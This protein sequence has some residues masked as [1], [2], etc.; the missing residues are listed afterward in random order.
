MDGLNCREITLKEALSN[1]DKRIDSQFWTTHIPKNPRYTYL[2]IGNV[3]LSSQYGM[4]INMNTEKKGYPIF[5]MNELH[6]MLTDLEVE[7]YANVSSMEYQAFSLQN[8]D[9]LFNRTNSYE[10]V[11]R[12]GIYYKNDDTPFTYASYLVKFVPDSSIILPEYLTTFLNTGIGVKAIKARARQSVN[13]TNVNPEEVKEIEIPLLSMRF[14][15]AIE[16]LFLIANEKRVCARNL[17]EQ[18]VYALHDYLDVK[19]EPNCNPYSEKLLSASF[20]VSGRFDAE[21]YQPKYERYE[22]TIKESKYGFTFI[23]YEFELISDKCDRKLPQYKYVEIGDINIGTG[24]ATPNVVMTEDLPDNAKIMT[25]VDDILVS[26]VRPNRGA[27]SILT[28]NDL[29]VSGAFT[30]LRETGDYPKEVLQLLLRSE[31]YRDWMLKYNVGTS[32][33]V[34]KDNDVLNLPIPILGK[35]EKETIVKN[36]RK[37]SDLRDVSKHLLDLA[38]KTVEM[39]I[40]QNED[41][42]LA[43]LKANVPNLEV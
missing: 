37:S 14:Q 33:P 2:K 15:K 9:V 10:W 28:Q 35:S 30:V 18:A 13:Q 34:I 42:A 21:Y 12:T 20:G 31:M 8:R 19:L 7:K 24:V 38:V 39:A 3:I 1:K 40:E 41:A 26:T 43:W 6:H 23:K 29:L 11:G 32:Y 27:V 5:R 36:V 22:K 17:Y 4:S 25:K 16:K